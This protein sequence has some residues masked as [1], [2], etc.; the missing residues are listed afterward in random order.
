MRGTA[1]ED[2]HPRV[3]EIVADV[4]ERGDAALIAW[5]ARFDGEPQPLRVAPERLRA[6]R[7]TPDSLGAVRALAGAVPAVARRDPALGPQH[8]R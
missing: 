6:A 2:V 4:R 3:V 8:R 7:L 1:L 5:T